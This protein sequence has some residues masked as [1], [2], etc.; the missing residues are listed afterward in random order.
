MQLAL[1]SLSALRA[2][3]AIRSGSTN[4][5]S[6]PRTDLLPP[7]PAPAQRWTSRAI[8]LEELGFAEAPSEKR[9]LYVAV[10]NAATRIRTRGIVSTTYTQLPQGAFVTLGDGVQIA[11]PELVFAEAAAHMDPSVVALLGMELC[12][13]YSR[14]P[15]APRDGHVTFG[16]DPLTTPERLAAFL[17]QTRYVRGAG[18]AS[19]MLPYVLGNAWSPMEASLAL[20]LSLGADRY[21]YGLGPIKLNARVDAG[22][23]TRVPD[24]LF[25]GTHVG[26]NY[27]GGDH[28]DEEGASRKRSVADKHRDRDLTSAGYTVLPVTIEDLR[29]EGGLDHVVS[30]VLDL[31]ERETGERNEATRKTLASNA[32]AHVRQRLICSTLPGAL[33]KYVL[34]TGGGILGAAG[35][36]VEEVVF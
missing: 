24:I 7:S 10:P 34:K 19:K 2:W 30:L 20:M 26:L 25:L 22:K 31:I 18:K 13:C 33:G 15:L 36:F 16:L 5:G 12:G 3:R 32:E 1:N 29:E 23:G 6:F 4:F 28:F 17:R 11:C 21:G 14:D 35:E 9:P 8:H 27:D